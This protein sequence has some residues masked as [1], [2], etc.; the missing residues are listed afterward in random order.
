[1]S[2]HGYERDEGDGGC[3]YYNGVPF[4]STQVPRI[5]SRTMN[6]EARTRNHAVGEITKIE[7]TLENK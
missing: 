2:Q 3:E 4:P 7:S 1:M 6:H 5:D